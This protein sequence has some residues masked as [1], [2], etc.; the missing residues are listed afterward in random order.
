MSIQQLVREI[1]AA[2]TR[3]VLALAGGGSRAISQLLEMPGASR[4]VLEVVVPYS[5][6]A[7]GE[8]LGGPPEHACSAQTARALGMAAFLRACRFGGCRGAF[9]RGCPP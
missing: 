3:V 8:W 1:H 7:L 9:G 5:A 2:P 4:T 6:A